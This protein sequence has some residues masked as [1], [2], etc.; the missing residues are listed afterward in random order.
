MCVKWALT[1]QNLSL[2]FPTKGDSNQ[3]PKL[4]RLARILKFR[5]IIMIISS[6]NKGTDQSAGTCRLV[7]AFVVGK[8]PKTGF[9]ASRRKLCC[10][11]VEVKCVLILP[12]E[13]SSI[14]ILS[15]CHFV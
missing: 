6:N 15:K 9:L 4:P 13:V 7:C 5:L 11:S 8:P 3:S 14:T 12:K 2:G 10:I 1:Q